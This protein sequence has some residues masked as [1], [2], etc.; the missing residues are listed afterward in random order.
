MKLWCLFALVGVVGGC[1]D[2]VR[3][4]VAGDA[5]RQATAA[6]PS[7]AGDAVVTWTDRKQ[8]MTGFGAAVVYYAPDMTA[9]DAQFL[10]SQ[11]KGLGLSLLRV[12]IGT[13]GKC[14][15][16][17]SAKKAVPYGVRVWASSWTPPAAWK[18]NNATNGM[19]DSHLLASHYGD[20]AKLL[21]D[22][23]D[24]MGG[25]GVPLFGISV[26]NEPDY[27]S[28]W[29]GCGWSGSQMVTFI[30]DNLGP[31]LAQRGFKGTVILPET[32]VWGNVSGFADPLFA[33][34]KAKG[35]VGVI[36]THPYGGGSLTYS[37]PRDNGKEFWQTETS[38]EGNAADATM[39]S[40]LT[41]AALL[42][43][44]VITAQMNA[45]H[46]WATIG[47]ATL[48]DPLR[49]N[50]AL[51]Q[52]GVHLKRGYVLGQWAKFVRPGFWR[53]GAT[54]LPATGIRVSAFRDAGTRVSIVAVNSGS[55]ARM[56]TFWL[57]GASFGT[58]WPWV[59]S[60]SKSLEKQATLTATNT[61]SYSLPPKS[62]T[63][64]VN[65]EA[66]TESTGAGG[67][68]GGA[69][70]AG[71]GAGGAGMTGIGG[72][73]ATG[74]G[75]RGGSGGAGGAGGR[76][77][78]AG[79]A[80]GAA[81][82]IIGGAGGGAGAAG[83]GPVDGGPTA[84]AGGPGGSATGGGVE[85]TGGV[86]GSVS[87]GTAG[88]PGAA[89]GAAGSSSAGHGG[90]AAGGPASATGGGSSGCSCEMSEAQGRPLELLSFV[91]VF[92]AFLWHRKGRARPLR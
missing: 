40:A 81:G 88:A 86:G 2:G 49:Q 22:Y 70:G 26:Q 19:G 27:P 73:M 30:R 21:A 67:A 48:D 76:G 1:A 65:W 33:D 17:E 35:Y 39:T 62:V 10:F 46:Y 43:D 59:T 72:A 79:P 38:Q 4:D 90:S 57:D 45:W 58:V 9:A 42:Q 63:T 74:A 28:S 51:I 55:S 87:S 85:T 8:T 53:V 18:A 75:G 13:D 64:F 50:P 52:N 61:F 23:A 84:D 78:A 36:A 25:Q 77:G 29:D 47:P 44:H 14:P 31:L 24:W 60:D 68:G 91:G 66:D 6:V 92:G 5:D 7:A 20:F 83:S 15:E 37:A 80:S 41:M 11:P 32:A 16:V 69:G 82:A 34:S 12:S 56:Q 71:G 3:G 89:G 54:E